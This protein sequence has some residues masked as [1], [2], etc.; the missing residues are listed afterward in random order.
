M[1]FVKVIKDKAYFKR[2]QVKFKRRREGKTDYKARKNLIK[3]DKYKYSIPK[4]RFVVR[5]TN[6]DIVCQIV[7]AKIV[8]DVVLSEMFFIS[9]RLLLRDFR[10]FPRFS[11]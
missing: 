10:F 4:Y 1:P 9:F 3:Q 6:K 11:L 8:G 5:F 2:Y 7:A